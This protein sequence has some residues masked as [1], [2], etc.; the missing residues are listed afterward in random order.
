MLELR[1]VPHS[2]AAIAADA[3][4]FQ[5]GLRDAAEELHGMLF[6][7]QL[8][9]G[10]E[11]LVIGADPSGMIHVSGEGVT[12][13]GGA[14]AG[15]GAL[16]AGDEVAVLVR[17]DGDVGQLLEEAKNGLGDRLLVKG[18]GGPGYDVPEHREQCPPVHSGGNIRRGSGVAA[19]KILGA[20]GSRSVLHF[21]GR[22]GV[23]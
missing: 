3:G 7:G 6:A 19:R 10:A 22:T 1:Q 18:G 4:I 9:G 5:P 15:A 16:I 11:G 21:P 2:E 8:D 23:V 13:R 17:A 12:R 20:I 14:A